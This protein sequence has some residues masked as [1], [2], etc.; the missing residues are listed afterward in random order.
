[1]KQ[2][3]KY[4][5][6]HLKEDFNLLHYVTVGALLAISLY[7]NYRI[8]FED[9]FLDFQRGVTKF[10]Y[11]FLFFSS[12]YYSVLITYTLF[13]GDKDFWKQRSFWIR[14]IFVLSL[15]S[16][17]S[18]VPFLRPWIN[19]LA[20]PQIQ[21][22]LYKVAVNLISVFLIFL[23]LMIFY[24]RNDRAEQHVYGLKPKHFD[25]SPYFFMLLIMLPLIVG[26]SFHA[27]FQQQYPM[28]K[29]TTA[30]EFLGVPEWWLAAAYE[31]AYGFDFITVEL[32]F[33][34]FMVIGMMHVL[35]RKGVLAMAATYCFLHFG[36]PPGEAISS[37]FGGYILGVIAYETKSIWGG[38]IVHV[39]IAWMMELVAFIGK[40]L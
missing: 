29:S 22:W 4:L 31:A 2:I 17:D 40:A 23:P 10:L 35:G 16:L 20:R 21:Y 24:F 13:R 33:R 7:T 30:H 34:G 19:E 25:Y 36:K 27:S 6:G 18:S 11:Y 14:S 15:L 1:M 38:I 5:T 32:L 39:G 12:A 37:I 9:S 28:Y 3:W 26:A 8:D